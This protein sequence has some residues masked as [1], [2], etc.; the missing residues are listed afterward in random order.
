VKLSVI[1]REL[2]ETLWLI[3]KK[4]INIGILAHADAGKTSLTENILFA[5]NAIKQKGSVDKGTCHT[6]FLSVEKERGISVKAAVTSC[7]INDCKINIIDT[8]GHID[9]SSEIDRVLQVLD[10]AIL[11]VSAVEG[12]Q[13]HT[14]NIFE[15]LEQLKIPTLIFIN[16]IDRVGSDS[17]MV[18]KEIKKE[19]S[20][21]ILPLYQIENEET[22]NCKLINIFNHK[23]LNNNLI[24]KFADFDE[25]ILDK[26]LNEEKINFE[27]LNQSLKTNFKNNHIIPIIL[28]SAKAQIGINEII[29]FITQYSIYTNLET[30]PF[31]G[32]VF[33]IDH[34]KLLGKVAGIRIFSGK[35]KVRESFIN[36]SK[37]EEQKVAQLKEYHA[38]KFTD[39]NSS[40]AG[41]I[42]AITGISNIN[43]GDILGEIS[44]IKQNIR[45]NNPLLLVKVTPQKSNDFMA[46]AMALNELWQED[47]ALDYCYDK[48]EQELNIKITGKIQ[49][50][51]LERILVDRFNIAAKFEN[52]T[53]IYKETPINIGE[54]YVRYWMPKPCWAIVKFKIEPGIRN[55]GIEYKSEVGVN[56]ILQKYQNEIER[57]I[58]TALQQGIKG[59]E[60]TDIKITLIDGE[61]HNVHT[62]PGDFVV[63]TP[64]A[65]M[66]GLINTQTNFLEP[67]IS[68]KIKAPE[69]L[70][71]NIVSDITKMRGTFESPN[72]TENYFEMKGTLSVSTS[73]DHAIQ[74]SS[75]SSGKAKISTK[76]IGY[77]LC[78][79]AHGISRDYKGISPLDQAKYILKARKAIQ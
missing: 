63:A 24:E 46:L 28:G 25:T 1:L 50:E 36:Q 21:N 58:N 11:V 69:H 22:E 40:S 16:K 74:L 26:Y 35:I 64:M 31:S 33:R 66:N 5:T 39:L 47:P 42:V 70:L 45:I 71:G 52:P 6:D 51:I 48:D 34:D 72:I 38:N 10:C 17:E 23:C 68:F 18:F 4:I 2:C 56:K 78:D 14:K 76:F 8:P 19:L 13:A 49:I 27:D 54:G 30:Q 37:N 61:D 43:V 7:T 29:D 55:S 62:H 73:I 65:I 32:L 41:N 60:V 20:Q 44:D 3:M 67:I 75:I 15:I 53:V 59:W 57:T 79:Q 77:E 9:F 12:V